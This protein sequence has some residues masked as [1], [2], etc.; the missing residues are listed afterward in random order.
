M[1]RD[2]ADVRGERRLLVFLL[3]F[4]LRGLIMRKKV[5]MTIVILTGIL[6]CAACAE[7]PEAVE[8]DGISVAV[9]S[10]HMPETTEQS[11]TGSEGTQSGLA[12]MYG[13]TVEEQNK[14]IIS[15][16]NGLCIEQTVGTAE[17]EKI[18][19]NGMVDTGD[20]EYISRYRYVLQPVTEKLREELFQ[21]YFGECAVKA[22][23]DEKND[24]WRLD[25]S[26]AGGD[27][28]LYTTPCPRAG[29]TVSGEEV[30]QI[31]YRRVDLYPFKDNLL[32][33]AT[34]SKA[35]VTLDE[36]I[37]K[38]DN[39]INGMSSL[40]NMTV[41]YVHA[42]GTAGRRPYYKIVYKKYLDQL[43]VTAYNDLYFLVDD[44]GIEKVYGAI[45]SVE[46]TGLE[47]LILSA[48]DAIEILANNI[49]L[50][51][52][53]K[54]NSIFVGKITLE[55][56][57]VNSPSGETYV[58]PSWRFCIGD[59]ENKRNVLRNHIL[60]VDAVTGEIIQE[61]RGNTF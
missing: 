28:Y 61:E 16:S 36:A 15:E 30:F 24:L 59:T 33:D 50:I 20:I 42:Y 2:K 45:Y 46:E 7:T 35:N 49:A 56:I 48:K 34:M 5:I 10:S 41:D 57:V 32:E 47:I 18:V 58:T 40:E 1:H 13:K 43:P 51:N 14:E 17:G 54:E 9:G 53:E 6:G 12:T 23:Y 31:E 52:F 38:C 4:L 37:K 8:R 44:E 3:L 21:A 19:I 60:A 55:Y 27:Y 25:N 11:L 22:K 29:L 26:S 39:I